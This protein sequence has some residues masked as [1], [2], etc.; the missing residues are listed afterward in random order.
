MTV[1]C[2]EIYSTDRRSDDVRYRAYTT[3]ARKADEFRRKVTRIPFTDSGHGLVPGVFEMRPGQRRKPV[4]T[5]L[6][7]HVHDCTAGTIRRV[8]VTPVPDKNG[9]EG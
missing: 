4:I 1:Y 7:E 5:A 8:T 3:S 9:G 6:A 2:L